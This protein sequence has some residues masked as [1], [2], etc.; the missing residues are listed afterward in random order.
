MLKFS[1]VD[2][3]IDTNNREETKNA[4]KDIERLEEI[5]NMRYEQR[6]QEMENDE[7]KIKISDQDINLTVSDINS[8]DEPSASSI[9]DL[10]FNDI[11]E[12]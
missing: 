1:D 9:P 7:D 5:S 8:F 11:E 4:P 3:L 12:L 2:N 6:K 10:I